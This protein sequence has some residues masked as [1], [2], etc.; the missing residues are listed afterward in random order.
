M[1]DRLKILDFKYNIMSL[2]FLF[3]LV[4]SILSPLSGNDWVLF[5][6]GKSSILTSSLTFNNGG[7]ISDYLARIF[8]N[9]K[10]LFA[11][12]FA[13]IMAYLYHLLTPLFGKVENK[14]HYL[15]LPFFILIL[16][17]E[18]FSYNIISVTGVVCYTIPSILIIIYFLYAYNKGN[19]KYKL[20][21][22]IILIL[23]ATYISLSTVHLAIAFLVSNAI[24]YAY[25]VVTFKGFPKQYIIIILLQV[26]LSLTSLVLIDKALLYT[27]IDLM[28]GNIPKF[29]NQT[30]SKNIL[31][32]IIGLIPI[33]KFLDEKMGTF[34]YKRVIIV[35]FSLVPILSLIYN[36]F[37]YS[38]VNLNLVIN[39][40]NGIFATENW[41][42]IIYYILYM[43]LYVISI[44]HFIKRQKSRM[45]ILTLL[46][47]GLVTSTFKIFS[48][49][50]MDGS[51]I[52]FVMTFILSLSVVLKEV[53]FKFNKW[54]LV[55]TSALCIY[56]LLL[57]FMSRYIDYGR[58][59]YIKEQINAG[60]TVVEVKSDPFLVVYRH[61]P[62]TPFLM[63]DFKKYEGLSDD[64]KIE[65]KYFG[66]FKDIESKVI[67][68]ANQE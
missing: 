28:L 58:N 49:D 9:N 26:V 19:D 15:L 34:S 23:I 47:T 33:N 21:D 11:L 6:H 39:K 36:F 64:I 57:L 53:E 18:T 29:I 68:S 63:R 59:K 22:Y 38:P 55:I 48:P 27:S 56:Y 67:E 41:Y 14:Y 46:L 7:L 1:K 51:N 32:F 4:I 60:Y 52:L 3:I 44:L 12:F 10:G 61:N 37:N 20:I 24:Y 31:I 45:Y 54:F 25:R 8:I 62:S 43:L 65:L 35:L 5:T 50:F 17:I 13:F 2:I 30:F 66:I 42:F 40:Y 16:G